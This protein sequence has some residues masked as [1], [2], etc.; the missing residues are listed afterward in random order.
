MLNATF[1]KTLRTSPAALV[2]GK[3]I[4]RERWIQSGQNNSEEIEMISA[5]KRIFQK[6]D[7]VLVRVEAR[8]KDKPRFEGPYTI[9]KKI[10]DRDMFCKTK[11]GRK[12]RGMLKKYVNILKK[13]DVRN[14]I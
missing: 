3:E 5:T 8:T 13:G 11:E 4:R 10:H 9:V 2:F 7:I 12:S 6:G 1:Q 14:E